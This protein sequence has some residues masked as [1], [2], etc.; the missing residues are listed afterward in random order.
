M[1]NTQTSRQKQTIECNRLVQEKKDI[2]S[3]I[4]DFE[5]I[6][7]SQNVGMKTALVDADGYPRGDIDIYAIKHARAALVPLYN[8]LAFK[9]VEIEQSL[10]ALHSIP[11]D[12]TEVHQ[13]IQI[14]AFAKV[15]GVAP[16]SPAGMSGLQRGDLILMFG[17]IDCLQSN[18]LE[19]IAAT[20]PALEFVSVFD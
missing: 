19:Q 16:D 7:R 3:K 12:P 2:E 6:L 5:S 4:Q 11:V 9:A 10:I 14:K 1:T 17:E 20:L 8:D 18:P 13:I 15:N